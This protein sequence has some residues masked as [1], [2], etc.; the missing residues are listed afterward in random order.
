MLTGASREISQ[1]ASVRFIVQFSPGPI[2]SFTCYWRCWKLPGT[3]LTPQRW[4]FP[5]GTMPQDTCTTLPLRVRAGQGT[6]HRE[7]LQG[8]R[9]RR[10]QR[11][12]GARA[13]HS[14]TAAAGE[15]W[16]AG[17]RCRPLLPAGP[18]PARA[19]PGRTRSARRPARRGGGVSRGHPVTCGVRLGSQR[20][21]PWAPGAAGHCG[22][23]GRRARTLPALD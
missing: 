17:T 4:H 14:G 19:A 7:P 9:Q 16:A 15:V 3:F 5:P 2:A 8:Q 10:S 22:G 18:A 1:E 21:R 11:A 6:R 13:P 12:D 23:G 20:A